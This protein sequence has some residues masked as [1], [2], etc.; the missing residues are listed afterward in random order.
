MDGLPPLPKSLSGFLNF[1]KESL[2]RAEATLGLR[3]TNNVNSAAP[4]PGHATSVN[5][6]SKIATKPTAT[7]PTRT[8]ITSSSPTSVSKPSK[9]LST[10]PSLPKYDSFSGFFFIN[11]VK[12]RTWIKTKKF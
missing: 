1:S 12:S 11:L 10:A 9:P 7:A 6:S 3:S 4:G 5:N 2:S 8:P